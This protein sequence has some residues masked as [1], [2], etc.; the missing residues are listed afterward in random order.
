MNQQ[1]IDRIHAAPAEL[2]LAVTGGG[3]T[4]ITD[5]LKVAGA[6]NTVLEA[7]IPYHERSL[8]QF[9]GARSPQGCTSATARAMAMASWLRARDLHD[10][11][12]LYG[13][14]CTAAIAT[15]RKRR[16][17]D[18]C[19]I[20]IQS[21][22]ATYEVSAQFTKSQSREVQESICN[23][24]II[25]SIGH[26]LSL[27]V[28]P[29]SAGEVSISTRQAHAP[30]EWQDLLLG[31]LRRETNDKIEVLFPGAFNPLHDGHQRIIDFATELLGKD[32]F[33]EISIRNVDKPPLDFLEMQSRQQQIGERHL[34]F[35]NAPTF[36]EKAEIF[37]NATFLVGCDT[38]LRIA[39]PKYYG[40]DIVQR[41]TAIQRIADLGTQFLVFGRMIDDEF[42]TLDQ[43][44]VPSELRLLCTQV[45]ESSFRM[46]IS[47]TEIRAGAADG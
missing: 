19:H 13:V 24:L 33:L 20:A 14:G 42:T 34:V 29:S 32:V 31:K 8:R 36:A 16:G 7:V 3:A 6:S 15:N 2:V 25:E 10:S 44:D 43:L 39:D 22:H 4:A 9:L 27:G 40:D 47:S 28:E 38:L 17:D 11:A 35:S 45:E 18:R 5:L 1:L 30:R 12:N 26:V 23:N 41:N 46:D 21:R 37:P